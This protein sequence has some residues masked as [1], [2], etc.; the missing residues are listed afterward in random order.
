MKRLMLCAVI[1]LFVFSSVFAHSPK[2]ID[3]IVAGKN[4]SVSISHPVSNP[5]KHYVKKVE[6]ILNNQKIIEQ[7]FSVQEGNSQEVIYHIP[8]L[9]ISDTITVKAFC[10]AGGSQRKTIIVH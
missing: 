8:S 6:V 10:N 9:K 1:M 2:S 5:Q 3:I 7:T 4:I